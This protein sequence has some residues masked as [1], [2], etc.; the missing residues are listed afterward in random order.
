MGLII[1]TLAALAGIGLAKSGEVDENDASTTVAEIARDVVTVGAE[2]LL[3]VH[4][5]S[6]NKSFSGYAKKSDLDQRTIEEV[7]IPQNFAGL[8]SQMVPTR[9]EEQLFR[10]VDVVEN[11]DYVEITA[12]HVW[13]DNLENYTLWKPEATTQYTAAAIAR[14]ILSNAIS[15]ANMRVAS[16]CT[17]TK[18]GKDLDFERKNL[19][20][21]FLD[22]EK[23][24]CAKFG[25]SLIR[26]N[27]D[28]YVLKNVGY[29]R[30]LVIQNGKN[31]LGV[32]RNES[33]ENL[34]NR[35]IPFGKDA[36]GNIVWLNNNGNK[37]VDSPNHFY[38]YVNYPK[39]E[40]F[41]TGLQIGKDG[42]TAENIQSKL[43]A[44]GQAR[45]TNDK[46]DI[47]AVEMKIEFIS[48]GDTEEYIQYRGLD[49]VY[50]YDIL[51][52][53]DTVRGYQYTAQV[54]AVEHDILTGMLNSV[55]IGKL[56]NWDGT[57]K[58][59][60][61][62]VPEV[63][64]ENI[65][66]KS[67]MAGTFAPGAI[68]GDDIANGTLTVNHLVAHTITADA[69]AAHTITANEISSHT[70]TSDEIDVEELAAAFGTIDVLEAAIAN[71]SEA[72][73]V[74]AD[75]S[76]AQIKDLTAENFV[77]HDA[78]TDRYFIDKLSVRSAQMVQATVGELIVKAAD[79]HYYRL[80][81]DENGELD[82]EDV[83]N[84][85]T[86]AEINAGETADGHSAIIETDLTV[87]DLSATNLK[88]INALIDKI[89]AS[90]IDVDEL[91]ARTAT[92][93]ALNT[94]DIRGNTYLQLMV[95]GY[96]ST[97][98]QWT[99]PATET[100]N[101][102][103]NGD[104]WYKGNP[105]THAQMAS[106]T[107]NQLA[108]YTHKGLEGYI[109]YMRKDGAWQEVSDPV[110]AQHTIAQIALE[111]EEVAIR[112]QDTWEG[113]A[114][115]RVQAL[116]IEARVSNTEGALTVVNAEI[117]AIELSVADKYGIV[118]GID[119]TSLGVDVSGSKHINLDVD[120]NNYV[121]M[122]ASAGIDV[123]G[124]RVK[125]NGKEVFARDDILILTNGQ[126]ES[127][128]ISSMSG[129]HDWVLIKPYYNA[130]IDFTYSQDYRSTS[131]Q[132]NT[133]VVQMAKESAGA[134]SFGTGAS[135]YQY[136]LKGDLV[137][138]SSETPSSG[139]NFTM[140]LSNARG[141]TNEV[142][143]QATV[144]TSGNTATFEISSG[145]VTRNLCG[146]GESI[147]LRL[148]SAYAYEHIRNLRLV[149]T[150]DSTTSRVPCTVYY[151]P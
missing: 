134:A 74:S 147:W 133:N 19:V 47:P 63:N 95:Q 14:N 6:K 22:P 31:L 26:D 2:Q 118:S 86:S 139:V 24:L 125:V 29:D 112:V 72:T 109:Q 116:Q 108:T 100:G 78:V 58:I 59:A 46:V 62:Q 60:T 91:F 94:V 65:R 120:A 66:L 150:C 25:L 141:L 106:F 85:L 121:H 16:D 71:I 32:E 151:F 105:M 81:I 21:A 119:I 129:K 18:V 7:A 50:L 45:F 128:V 54:V 36:N 75:I 17:D 82:T 8:E 136:V 33:I 11:E 107:H 68:Y 55:T 92:I 138:Q 90:R 127:S 48:L 13:Y 77:A 103:K 20:E 28:C 61:W 144:N 49:K 34:A 76:V 93:T 41:D 69:I 15:P 87:A 56:D 88:A 3:K 114:S 70:I 83:T 115:L 4:A 35:V 40:M 143:G 38:D 110:E 12:R 132:Y 52:I 104:V 96:G 148:D 149:C 97:Y 9:L 113:M 73:I 67:I 51:S 131:A 142:T 102:V 64:G 126:S 89:T 44:A 27:W 137:R 84:S 30:G 53:K 124:K 122:S 10:V 146:E 135:W 42:V 37:W 111:T 43:L 123:K 101:T 80:T 39:A 1:W 140:H 130:E 23:G 5:K 117:D 98:V 99:D 57:R 79:D 145:H